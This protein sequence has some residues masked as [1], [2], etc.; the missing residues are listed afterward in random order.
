[1]STKIML[2]TATT[3]GL[4]TPLLPAAAQDR[5]SSGPLAEVIVTARKR[6][7]SILKVPVVETAITQEALEQYQIHDLTSLSSK[8]PGLSMGEAV[9]SIGPQISIRGVGTSTLDAG[10]DQSVSLN[11]DG[12]SMTQGL[13]YKAGLFDLAQAEVLKGPQALFFGKNS[14]GGV[15]ALRTADPGTKAEATARLGYEFEAKEQH[16]ELILSTPLTDTFGVRLAGSFSDADG[17]FHD[18]ATAAPGTGALSPEPDHMPES[19]SDIWRGTAVWK[20]AEAFDARLKLN[21]TRDNVNGD[22]GQGQLTSCPDGEGSPRGIP[23]INPN[24]N[25]R[26]DEDIYLVHMDPAAFPG[27]RNG[28]RPFMDLTQKFGTLEL[29]YRPS[30]D[31]TL[32]SVTGYYHA[33]A[34]SLINGTLAGFAATTLAADNHFNRKDFTQE[35][36]VDTEFDSPV[37]FTGGAFYQDGTV[38]NRIR[39]AG[40]TAY[41]LPAILTTGSHEIDIKSYS[42]FGQARWKPVEQL[43][44]AGGVRWAH[45]KRGD[46]PF[47]LATGVPVY[48]AP[49]VPEIKADNYSPEVSLTYT[50]TDDLTLFG[51]VKQGYKSGSFTITTPVGPGVN[52]SFGDEK[53]D[54]GEIGLKSRLLDRALAFNAAAY[55]Y[56]YK[57]LQVGTNEPAQNGIP[58]IRTLNAGESEVYG[59]DIDAAYRVPFVDRLTINAALNWN[60]AR[61]TTLGDVPCWG[62]Q[63]IARGCNAVPNLTGAAGST[64]PATGQPLNTAQGDLSGLALTRA[65]D[66]QVNAGVDYELPLS[67]ALAMNFGLAAQYTSEYPRALNDRA[68]SVQKGYT[69]LNANVSAN[70]DHWE[71]AFIANNLTNEITSGSCTVLNY[72]AGQIL[73]GEVTGGASTGIA[74][75]D[76]NTCVARR[77]RELWVR[78]TFK[79]FGQ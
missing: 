18:K 22:A 44:L 2:L 24:D 52:N 41:R 34:D 31:I 9:L 28:G 50:P 69:T 38:F 76:E 11:I 73:G 4:L 29:N 56:V 14:P 79:A 15:I 3:V 43:E 65:P 72:A 70:A 30:K 51:S 20:P 71:V 36:R 13:A 74:G 64:D 37:N 16:A 63:T 48:V 54:G 1:M 25:C 5:A 21:W 53:V 67:D 62:G 35:L 66:W 42:V 10:V 45:E 7:E 49:G 60:H 32:T 39:V 27:I 59:L 19:R 6:Q 57:G 47:S 17:F 46:T 26:L 33:D 58:I 55:Y 12:L 77:G 78:L 23:F 61:F 68:D 40:N 75:I 8:V